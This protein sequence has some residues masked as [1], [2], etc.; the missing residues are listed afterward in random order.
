MIAFGPAYTD[1]VLGLEIAGGRAARAARA[2]RLRASTTTGRVAG[3]DA[4]A[5]ATCAAT[6]TSSRRS[7]ASGSRTCRRRCR[8]RQAMFGRLTHEQRLRR[9]VEDVLVGAGLL[10]GVHVLAAARRSRPEGDR[11]AGAALVAA[12]RAAHDARRRPAR[13]RAAQRRHAGTATSRCSRSRTSTCR[14]GHRCPE[15]RW[16]LGGIVQGDF[17][18]REGRRRGGL[19][20]AARRAALRAC[21]AAALSCDGRRDGAVRLGRAVRAARPGRRVE[22]VRARPRRAVRARA[23]ADPLPRR[24]HVPAAAARTSRSSSTRPCRRAS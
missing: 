12:A 4:G 5:P 23:G 22:R 18:R 13:R 19:R 1:E 6:S 7:R 11:A 17:F 14:R 9:Q 16:R 20:R 24:D 15:E 21:A 10:R 2:A 8:S 3:A